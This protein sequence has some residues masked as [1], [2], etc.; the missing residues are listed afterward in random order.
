MLLLLSIS[1]LVSIA[2]ARAA[3]VNTLDRASTTATPPPS[4]A[5]IGIDILTD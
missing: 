4:E 5:E 3:A 1:A 2:P